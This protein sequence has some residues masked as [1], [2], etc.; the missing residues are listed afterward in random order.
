MDL[1][2]PLR[3]EKNTSGSARVFNQISQSRRAQRR[4]EAAF[5][6]P[7]TVKRGYR[8]G[9]G[10]GKTREV[11]SG[12]L[13]TKYVKAYELEEEEKKIAEAHFFFCV[14]FA[15]LI[16]SGV[17]AKTGYLSLE[18]SATASSKPAFRQ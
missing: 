8:R 6:P 3:G 12:N 11:H 18:R 13:K 5:S 9:A 1:F 14:S 4:P 17:F 7:S 16:Q 15:E 10:D 2:A